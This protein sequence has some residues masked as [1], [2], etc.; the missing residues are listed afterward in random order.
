MA[1]Y[2]NVIESVTKYNPVLRDH[3]FMT[4]GVVFQD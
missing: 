3:I 1:L 4:N 2:F